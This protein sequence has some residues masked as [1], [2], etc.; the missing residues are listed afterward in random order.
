VSLISWRVTKTRH[1]KSAFDG[2]GARLYPGRWNSAG[3]PVVYTSEHIALA[4][5]EILVHAGESLLPHYTAL[6]ATFDEGLVTEVG[7]D[8]LPPGWR[9]FPALDELKRVG[10]AW[11]DSLRSPVLKVPSAVVP[12]S[13][14][15]LL[16]PLH[17]DFPSIRLGDPLPLKLDRRLG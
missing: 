14:S 2:E 11:L 15:F 5:L 7:E 9:G 17:P 8:D 10:D 3:H 1:S 12:C 4:V 6:S 16:N 13:W